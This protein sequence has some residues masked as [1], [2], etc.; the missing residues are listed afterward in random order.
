MSA[1]ID[2]AT[3]LALAFALVVLGRWGVRNAHS[4]VPHALP[5]AD[6]ERRQRVIVRGAVVC[7]GV[8]ALFVA[9]AVLRVVL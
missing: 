2:S 6:R 4:V 7:Q 3:A 9:M 1:T 5:E 8:A